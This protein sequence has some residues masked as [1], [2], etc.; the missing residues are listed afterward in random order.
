MKR[1][2]D[3]TT[4]DP[5]AKHYMDILLSSVEYDTFVKLMRLMRPV[6]QQKILAAE[7]DAK[8][9]GDVKFDSPSKSAAKDSSDNFESGVPSKAESKFTE[10]DAEEKF[11]K[12]GK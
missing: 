11:E 2:R 4:S 7:S 3:A 9:V 1:C 6:A 8:T 12:G 5:R 10:N